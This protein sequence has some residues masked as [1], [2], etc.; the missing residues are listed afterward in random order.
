MKPPQIT[1]GDQAFPSRKQY[2]VPS[3]QRNYV[4]TER[5][6]WEPL[7]EDV[8]ELTYQVVAA[9]ETTKPHFLG[10]IITK[11]IDTVGFINCWWVVDG[12]QRLT[13][14]QILIAAA[15]AAFTER[16]LAQSAGIL[17]DLLANADRD[18]SDESDKY[19]IQHKSSDYAQ[20]A[21]IINA[22]LS[23]S[24]DDTGESRLDKCY[25]YFL[26]TVRKWLNSL[27][28]DQLKRHAGALTKAIL[29]HLQVVD[30]RLDDREN[31]HAIFEALNARGEPLT[32]WEK[33]KNYILSVAVAV[34]DND[35]DGDRTYREHLEPY[36]AE[37][38][39]NETVRGPRFSGKRI[40][41]F[42]FY[43]AQL[44]LPRLRR[45]VSGDP[46]VR[47]LQRGRLYREFRYIGEHL[48]RRDQTEFLDMLKRL[49]RY[50]D[51][52]RRLDQRTGFSDYA[53]KVM[54]RRNVLA[55]GSLV[56]VL[57]ELV[58]KLGVGEELDD[59][60]R[61][62]DSYLMRRVALK[63]NYSGFDDV[64]FG[65]VQSLRDTPRDRICA[66]LIEQL[67]ESPGRY[68]WPSDDEL[69]LHLLTANM[70]HGISSGR[71]RLLLAGIAE[72][73]HGENTLNTG[74]FALKPSLT[75]EHIAP[76]DWERHW[77]LDLNFGNSEEDRIRLN[78][79]IHRI[80]NLTL[81]TEAINPRLG[82]QPWDYKVELLKK[83]NLEMN[84]RL[85]SDMEETVWN[86]AE[87][88]RRSKQLA[89]YVMT[90]W[91]HA[92][93][94]RRELGL[95]PIER[96]DSRAVSGIVPAT[97]RRLV[98]AVTESG[99]EGSWLNTI[100]LNRRR[101]GDCYGRYLKI[102]GGDQ[103][104]GAWFGVSKDHQG[105][106]LDFWM[107]AS[108]RGTLRVISLPDGD[109]FEMLQT[110]TEQVHDI[111]RSISPC[112]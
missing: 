74:E 23:S 101:R 22:A 111:A 91:P 46:D 21:A 73:M 63:A 24:L 43:F 80:G 14:L 6:H 71:L 60:L 106:V 47:P 69:S 66:V 56:P 87:I 70:Y 89:K 48:Y 93:V 55:L 13:T 36:D 10:A 11:E 107:P 84:R 52:Y 17:S 35:R 72:H 81:V 37:Q 57:M 75:I 68:R 29:N 85:L 59:A 27:A 25:A 26:R 76:Q 65:H 62:V 78:R 18:I 4:W 61:I 30:I 58:A 5:D 53:Q 92:D 20:F 34:R 8:K 95:A 39:W 33:T 45:E 15:R 40:D 97:A 9:E 44:E 110:A 100:G 64:A 108:A 112:E 1:T 77:H 54:R 98:D 86:E 102:G 32:E 79:L 109:F 16:G 41:L 38:Y 7:W 2:V 88:D 42:L 99:I 19:K 67:R 82:N 28:P 103:W 49:A 12:Q 83:D 105:L 3:Y 104:H 31:S 90:I 51:I 94:L 50:A 96:K